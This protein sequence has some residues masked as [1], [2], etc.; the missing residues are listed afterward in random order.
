MTEDVLT[1]T[2]VW[3]KCLQVI[4]DNINIQSFRTWFEPIKPLRLE[5]HVLT[6]QVPSQFFYEWIEEH[7]IA[8]LRRTLRHFLGPEAKLEYS[9]IVENGAAEAEKVAV[10]MPTMTGEYKAKNPPVNLPLTGG[11]TIPNPFVIP[12]LKK[13]SINPQLNSYYTFDSFIEGECNRLARTAGLA[14]ATRPG[15]TAFNPL[16]IYG[17]VGLG[18]THLAQAIGNEVKK[19]HPNKVVLYVSSEKFT[20]QFV[21]SIKNNSVSDFISFYQLVD[22]LIVD[23][24]QFFAGKER[25]QDIFF[26]VFNHLHQTD[27]QLI[28]TSDCPPSELKGMEERL[29]SRFKWGLS[30]DLQSPDLETRI[31]ILRNKMYLEGIT[32]PEEVTEYI[33][34]NI[35]SNVRELEGALISLLAQSS[36][37]RKDIDIDLAQ[38]IV[39]NFV[40]N[41][42]REISIDSIQKIVSD[43]FRLPVEKLKEKTRKREIVQARQISM[44]FAKQY[45]KSS[46]KTIGLHFGGRDHSTVIHALH[47]VDDLITTDKE[48]RRYVDDIRKK[49]QLA[50]A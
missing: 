27:R 22:V 19:N 6:I 24:I 2:D 20:N 43:Y 44:F 26:H 30:A 49:I 15:Q 8:L 9:V 18:K 5:G 50:S 29:L 11:K 48:F 1:H 28:L 16:L 3:N 17:G 14:V 25:T 37:N 10:S 31:A 36:F 42:S 23:D 41:A 4:R 46:L 40:K 47:T 39:K 38:S 32:I 21:D 34:H 45:T 13:V 7:Y 35:S 12:G 33:A